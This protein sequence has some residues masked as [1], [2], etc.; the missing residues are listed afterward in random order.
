M[1]RLLL[2]SCVALVL[3]APV[4]AT[5]GAAARHEVDRGLITRVRPPVLVLR[6]LDGSRTTFTVNPTTQITL[7]GRRV[8]LRRLVPGDVA[9]VRHDADFVVAVR[10]F[11]S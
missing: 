8:R 7:D 6:E 5:P 10:A 3:A 4:L 9:I 2:A 11:S 1:R